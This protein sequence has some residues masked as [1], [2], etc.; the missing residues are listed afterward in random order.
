MKTFPSPIPKREGLGFVDILVE[1]ATCV[2][3]VNEVEANR[4]IEE[5][6]K[7]FDKYFINERLTESLGVITFGEKQKEK[8][9]AIINKNKELSDKIK[10]AIQNKDPGIVDEKVI[11]FKTIEEVQGCEANHIIIS[12]TYGVDKTGKPVNRFGELNRDKLGKCIFNVAVTRAQ[13]SIT[14]IH[15]ILA[16]DIDISDNSKVAYIKEYLEI[17]EKFALEG[18]GQFV[19]SPVS[20]GFFNQVGQYLLEQGIE[21]DRIIYNYGVTEGSVKIPLVVLDKDKQQAL[22]GLYLERDLKA[23]Y[24]YLD[25]N[26]K[27][28]DILKNNYKWNIERVF[29]S[30][31]VF[32][33]DMVKNK[34]K[35]MLNN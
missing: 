22:F 13:K 5:L 20:K 2:E 19:S 25:Y 35:K 11:F 34:I 16:R 24:N 8:I 10:L 32:N 21:E 28:F 14:V 31:W 12:F 18:K 4:V 1:N 9:L 15:S 6:N 7:L 23:Q 30:D 3:G 17:S 29:I 27:Y 33:Q 26:I